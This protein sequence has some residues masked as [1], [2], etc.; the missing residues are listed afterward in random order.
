[1]Y[2]FSYFHEKNNDNY[3]VMNFITMRKKIGLDE[4]NKKL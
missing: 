4:I 2:I 3:Y 1:M